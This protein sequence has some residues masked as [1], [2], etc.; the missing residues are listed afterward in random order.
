[1][2]FDFPGDVKR[3]AVI[4]AVK[5]GTDQDVWLACDH[6]TVVVP[7]RGPLFQQMPQIIEACSGIGAVGQGFQQCGLSTS[8]Y[9]DCNDKFCRWIRDRSGQPVIQ[10]N[11][12]DSRVIGEVHRVTKG[13]QILSGGVSCQPF[14]SLGDRREQHDARSISFPS[15]LRMGF[16]LNVIAIIM[17]CT[18]EVM[19]SSWAQS[20]LHAFSSISGYRV[21]QTVLH[22]HRTWPAYRTRWW[23]VVSHPAAS[24]V[25][26]PPMPDVSFAPGVLHLI[27]RMLDLPRSQQ[28]E[29]ECDLYE[30]RQFHSNPKGIQ[31]F[32]L[33]ML[34]PMPT[35]THSWGSQL[36]ACE[37]GCRAA[38]FASKRLEESGLYGVLWPL[39][40]TVTMNNEEIT[41]VRH[42]HAQEVALLCGLNPEY[43]KPIEGSSLRLDLPGVGQM[44]SPL[45]GAWVLSNF[46][47]SMHYH[48][49]YQGLVDTPQ[50]VMYRLVEDLFKSR[51]KVWELS[52][53]TPYMEIF[54]SA[55]LGILATVDPFHEESGV[56]T[57]EMLTAVRV[58]EAALTTTHEPPQEDEEPPHVEQKQGEDET[59]QLGAHF[60]HQNQL[61]FCNESGRDE[62]PPMVPNSGCGGSSSTTIA[63][64]GQS[65]ICLGDQKALQD[66]FEAFRMEV[67]RDIHD[68]AFCTSD[69]GMA[70]NMDSSNQQKADEVVSETHSPVVMDDGYGDLPWH[71]PFDDCCICSPSTHIPIPCF[72]PVQNA[73]QSAPPQCEAVVSDTLPFT[74]DNHHATSVEALFTESG[75]YRAFAKRKEPAESQRQHE[76]IPQTNKL[77]NGTSSNQDKSPK[78]VRSD[79]GKS[80]IAPSS[81]HF[82]QVFT[83][84]EDIPLFVKMPP[85]ATA[86]SITVAE[87]TLGTMCQ[88]IGIR[89]AV[90]CAIPLG[91]LTAPF[92]QIFMHYVPSHQQDS[93]CAD[94]GPMGKYHPKQLVPRVE[95]LRNQQAWVAVD[96]MQYY[97]SELPEKGMAKVHPPSSFEG[98]ET[99]FA[100]WVEDGMVLSHGVPEPVVTACIIDR[101]WIPYYIIQQ[102]E[103][104]HV[105]TTPEGLSFLQNTIFGR[106]E[107]I[108]C[109]T[110][111]LP[112][113]FKAD[114]G[115]QVLGWLIS[116]TE[117]R[118]IREALIGGDRQ[119]I[120]AMAP[121]TA[122]LWRRAFENHL[123]VSGKAKVCIKPTNL[124]LGGAVAQDS[125]EGRVEQL[126]LQ[127][128][129]PQ[130]EV[131]KRAQQVVAC[132]GRGPIIQTMRSKQDWAELKALANAQQPRLQLVL[133]SELA[134]VIKKRAD[135]GRPFGDKQKKQQ[136]DDQPKGPL[137]M[138]PQD[139]SIPDGLFKQGEDSLISQI[140]L[141]AIRQDA[142]GIV[143]VSAQQAQPYLKLA[144][145]LSSVG[146]AL[147]VMDHNDPICNGIGQIIRFPGRYEKTGEPFIG[148]G[149]LI[150]LGS[151]EVCR[152]YPQSQIKV[153]EVE[154]HVFRVVAYRDEYDGDWA[155]FVQRP[156]KHVLDFLGFKSGG[157]DE[158][159]IDVWDR[160]WLSHKLDRQKPLQSDLF[161]VSIRVTGVDEKQTMATSGNRGYY[162][163]PRSIDGR[164][165]SDAYRVVWLP[166]TDLANAITSL[167]AAKKWACLVRAG[168]RFG[169]R[170]VTDDAQHV[171]D[172][173]KPQTPFLESGSILH[174]LVGPL[175]FG[176]TKA[177][178]SRVFSKWGWVAR[179]VQPRGRSS[180]GG[181][182]LWEVHANQQPECE[183]YSM[184]HGDVI[185]SEMN[186]K[187]P[188]ERV[189]NDIVASARTMAALQASQ[190]GPKANGPKPSGDVVFDSD[191]WAGYVPATKVSKVSVTSDS[192]SSH[193]RQIEAISANVDRKIAAAIAQYDEKLQ[194][195]GGD[196]TMSLDGNDRVQNFEDR[197]SKMEQVVQAQHHQMQQQ[198]GHVNA[199]LTQMQKQIDQQSHVFQ[200]HLDQRMTEQ[201][202]QIEKLL[203]KKGRYEWLSIKAKSLVAWHRRPWCKGN[204]KP[205][206]HRAVHM[207]FWRQFCF[208][209]LVIMGTCRIGEAASP[210]PAFTVGAINPTGLLHK[211]SQL[212]MLP[213]RSIWGV[214]ETH[215]TSA[216]LHHFRREL[217]LHKSPLKCYASH[218]AP[219]LSKAT[220]SIGGKAA[221]VS[222]LTPFPGHNMH[223][224]WPSRLHS[225]ARTHAAA[226]NVDGIWIRIGVCYGYAK[227]AN[228]HETRDH[229]DELL[230]LLTERIVFQSNGPRAIIGDFNQL[231]GVLPQEAIWA[232]HGFV[233][234]QS[235][236][237][238]AWNKPIQP[239]CKGSTTKDFIWVSRE[240]LPYLE[241]VYLDQ[242]LFSDH[243][244]LMAQFKQ[245]KIPPPVKVWK[246]PV[247][248]PW[249]DIQGALADSP[250]PDHGLDT[251]QLAMSIAQRLEDQCDTAL[252]AA[253]KPGLLPLHRGRSQSTPVKR[254]CIQLCPQKSSR[255]GEFQPSFVGENFQHALWLKQV[256]RMHS[257]VK[258]LD[259][260][261]WDNLKADHAHSLWMAIRSAQGF[262]GGFSSFW[263]QQTFNIQGVPVALPH[264]IPTAVQAD[265]ILQ[266]FTEKLRHLEKVLQTNRITQAKSA[267]VKDPTKIYRDVARSKA[268]PVQTLMSSRVAQV[269]E[270]VQGTST[271]L[272]PEGALSPDE[273]VFGPQGIVTVLGHEPGKLHLNEDHGLTEGDIIT[274][275]VFY[276][277]PSAVMQ[278][279]EQL[280]MSFWGR[281]QHTPVEKWEPFID[282]CR[283]FVAPLFR[284]M[285][286]PPITEALWLS[287][288]RSRKRFA[289][290]GPDGYSRLDL[291]NMP[292]SC[293][294]DLISILNRV[295]A[296][297]P[298]PQSWMTGII[299]ALEKRDGACKVTD[300][301]P[302]CIFSLIY[303]VWGSI[304][305]RQILEHLSRVA[306]DELIGNRPRR[307]TAHVWLIVS[308]LVEAGLS[309]DT[310]VV[311]AVADITKCF[312]ALPRIPVLTLA[313]MVG[314]SP[315][316]CRA[317]HQALHQMERRFTTQGCIGEALVSSCGFPE[318]DALS[319]CAMFLVNLAHHAYVSNHKPDVRAWSFVDD[320]Q[321]TGS[322]PDAVVEGM[323]CVKSFATM[324]D[325][326]L[327]QDKSFFWATQ[328][329][330]RQ[331]LRQQG[332]D[333][334]L[335]VRNLGGHVTFCRV[336]TNFTITCRIRDLEAFWGLL[337]RSV[338]PVQQKLLA[339]VVVAWP[340]ALHGISGAPLSQAHLQSLRTKALQCLGQ[341]KKGASPILTLSCIHPCRSD[342]G[343]YAI[344]TT[345]RVFRKL[346]LPDQAFPILN[347]MSRSAEAQHR[348]GPCGVFLDRI[349]ELAWSWDFDG[350]M[351]DHEG[352][353]LHILNTP[354][355]ALMARAHH[356]WIARVGAIVQSRD[357]FE[358]LGRV[359]SHFTV[360]TFKHLDLEASGILRAA[361]N[362]TFFTRDKQF[363]S[364]RFVDKQCPFCKQCDDSIFHRHWECERFQPSRNNINRNVFSQLHN[365]PECTLQHGWIVEPEC[366]PLFRHQ[367][368]NL[369]DTTG[370]FFAVPQGIE[371]LHIFTDGGCERPADPQLRVA[372][373]GACF[374]DLMTGQF[375]PFAQGPIPGLAQT[376]LRGELTA[377]IA[378]FRF[379]IHHG[380]H[381][382]V[383]T[384]NQ[385]VFEFVTALDHDVT[386]VPGVMDPDHDLYQQLYNLWVVARKK[387]LFGRIVKVRSHMAIHRFSEKVERWA[388]K[389]NQMADVTASRAWEGFT[390]VFLATWK[391][392]CSYYD[393]MGPLRDSIH[394]H[395]VRIG[396]EATASKAD[397]KKAEAD[398]WGSQVEA[399]PL[400]ET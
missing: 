69:G 373:F 368:V 134:A 151:I 116:L 186:R 74:I 363:A 18:K 105:F 231:A 323:Q 63:G 305:A 386:T 112:Q 166:K 204:T 215:L 350:W 20:V 143:V 210:G 253:G 83:P 128:G 383:W 385:R 342:P 97:L 357:G 145:P 259:S 358:G 351:Y 194:L 94:K 366:S 154:N 86:G 156:I 163:E 171:H 300:F 289:A 132:L 245:M 24:P 3:F 318:G 371:D 192:S 282:I 168:K 76:I 73:K 335:Y 370:D 125:P 240:L 209:C 397:L 108:V 294:S 387:D 129:V 170:T 280:W 42:L 157:E 12:A 364:G 175:P 336:P 376:V 167:Q 267:R 244:V 135:S 87:A 229:T 177:T 212:Q 172:Q 65:E 106:V 197:L 127:H 211:V 284:Q 346:C 394:A 4:N 150:Q 310:P 37:C 389:G 181:G 121:H 329:E 36:R 45:Q 109:H 328:A 126:L 225:T 237:Q 290:I 124:E 270:R 107:S 144:K 198:H 6:E 39:K 343:Y 137:V 382:W 230:S 252:K 104:T 55:I 392:M 91:S 390:E 114:C 82:V 271:I 40:Q 68:E 62:T 117:D 70:D 247:P 232:Q 272:Y 27:P 31:S 260:K 136:H 21:S 78:R 111:M 369:P 159:V 375:I 139:V 41:K 89:D 354:L 311:G 1:M 67:T 169:L 278:Q 242:H 201:L 381:F 307:E 255:Q 361:M 324:L 285:Q 266:G 95:V 54:R 331:V 391:Q 302:I 10:G 56:S 196:A 312:N 349:A 234:V 100:Q 16:Y 98:A 50:V 299:H 7:H 233:E 80:E 220:G 320:W 249:S 236:A 118:S 356:A 142:S 38:G 119:W 216:G 51:D 180:D 268:V 110:M 8:C 218:A 319:V 123:L 355:Q 393:M 243:A 77:G 85:D 115:F 275:E 313:R 378:A 359:D 281:H 103:K 140:A 277:E 334:K 199:Q 72:E 276:G 191:P 60:D 179:P 101:H 2:S 188:Q 306:P 190:T 138:S 264:G 246:K 176:A 380:K 348:F 92:Q 203:G 322:S 337:R 304:R 222:V 303:R 174:Y 84:G 153:D 205:A 217:A 120:S 61:P 207:P 228:N 165:P 160:Q 283:Q 148:T 28:E 327:D 208:V 57:Q 297:E 316:V 274:Q 9:I 189:H 158:G 396:E 178:L 219:P 248:L 263:Q 265:Q 52:S 66:A 333:V 292:Q 195:N 96:E 338:A 235:F 258:L 295:E 395:F 317:W 152:F 32:I 26:L 90:G 340:R 146:L 22:L 88:P 273:P 288:V 345:L 251:S 325:L 296:G 262:P 71:C 149:R 19:Q 182:I 384:D 254:C 374:A 13:E 93:T 239:T 298:W 315:G 360:Q 59:P 147:L 344:I 400:A 141:S 162:V 377:C 332:C 224:K 11:I 25:D 35:A 367:L 30:L 347:D 388:I 187:K 213:S 308:Q 193:S 183:A 291:L 257:L 330:H 155:D 14:S 269:L 173:Y 309:H 130:A 279:F 352:I 161:M 164:G 75:G 227:W 5:T 287:T 241:D 286:L 250:S 133:L 221:G 23:A 17:E 256:R 326:H 365:L 321:I 34:T 341:Q 64:Q 113:S 79:N 15:L 122:V 185:I 362:G 131:L 46:L 200:E 339:L 44:A 99:G 184:D 238:A 223:H 102:T 81:G 49:K 398:R 29:L 206:S 58:A 33:S 353:R 314:I 301:R 202:S 53:T 226:V 293:V 399:T 43:V 214:S 379:G 261:T 48:G 372:T 47:K